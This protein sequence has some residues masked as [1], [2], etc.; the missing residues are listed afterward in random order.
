MWFVTRNAMDQYVNI[1]LSDGAVAR[2]AM[3]QYVYIMLS[4]GPYFC[5]FFFLE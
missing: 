2:D 5:R 3:D 1:E 4:E